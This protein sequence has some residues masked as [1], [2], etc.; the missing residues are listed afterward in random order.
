FIA[1]LQG[2]ANDA[3]ICTEVESVKLIP[4]IIDNS[5]SYSVY[6]SNGWVPE[7]DMVLADAYA[8]SSMEPKRIIAHIKGMQFRRVRLDKFKRGLSLASKPYTAQPAQAPILAPPN[9]SY[10][11]TSVE[12]TI[13]ALVSETCGLSV[14]S[15]D[16][17]ADLASLG[18]DS[19]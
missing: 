10:R 13:V 3:Y 19:L 2:S 11:K 15:L 7:D 8:V 18:V 4:D 6:C 14:E 17:D 5:A 12:D 9:V 1:N 16:L